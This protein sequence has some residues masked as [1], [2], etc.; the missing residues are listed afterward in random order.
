[1]GH[2]WSKV[3]LAEFSGEIRP[4]LGIGEIH[5]IRATW[6]GL[7]PAERQSLAEECT[8]EPHE[9]IGS[10]LRFIEGT[11]FFFPSTLPFHGSGTKLPHLRPYLRKLDALMASIAV[12]ELLARRF[13]GD[14]DGSVKQIKHA[15]EKERA[16]I[17]DL[18][19]SLADQE[20]GESK[21]SCMR[22]VAI[23]NIDGRQTSPGRIRPYTLFRYAAQRGWLRDLLARDRPAPKKPKA[24]PK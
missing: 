13:S 22:A 9:V 15:V 1:L 7:A 10:V 21:E 17:V 20:S 6:E 2:I 18:G 8:W 16:R 3:R 5:A 12:L 24:T 14:A 23:L 19:E 4:S 11:G